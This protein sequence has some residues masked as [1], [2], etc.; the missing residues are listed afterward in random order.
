M[1]PFYTSLPI[2]RYI[3][4][5]ETV[6]IQRWI[7]AARSKE[8]MAFYEYSPICTCSVP[9]HS[10]PHCI[11]VGCIRPTAE[12]DCGAGSQVMELLATVLPN[13]LTKR[14]LLALVV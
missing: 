8:A 3:I 14:S 5:A 7:N 2:P 13:M 1:S 12:L 10:C 4:S 9:H 6:T 11:P